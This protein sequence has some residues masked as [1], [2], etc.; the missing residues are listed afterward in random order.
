MASRPPGSLR[1]PAGY[2]CLDCDARFG[3]LARTT[4]LIAGGLGVGAVVFAASGH[5]GGFIVCAVAAIFLGA[6]P[7]CPKCGS[8]STSRG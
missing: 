4:R 8:R 5:L 3:E 7:R 6:A 1:G 2:R